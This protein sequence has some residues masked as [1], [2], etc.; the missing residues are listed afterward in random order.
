MAFYNL[1]N[2]K[3]NL[4][5]GFSR[6]P[7]NIFGI[8]AKGYWNSASKLSKSLLRK[9]R[10]HEYEAYPIFFL[11]RHSLELYLKSIIYKTDILLYLNEPDKVNLELLNMHDLNILSTKANNI[12]KEIFYEDLEIMKLSEEII[13]TSKEFSDIDPYSFSFRY[14]ID[15][16]GKSIS[17]KHMNLKSTNIHMNKLLKKIDIIDFGIDIQTDIEIKNLEKKGKL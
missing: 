10:F 16:K 13:Q 2:D 5:I 4:E 1:I 14:P 8:Y 12:L 11:Y 3:N 7:K 17:R 9:V 15:T 6:K